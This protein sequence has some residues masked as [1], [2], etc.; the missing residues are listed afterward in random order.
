MEEAFSRSF[1]L[2]KMNMPRLLALLIS[3]FVAA[4]ACGELKIIES[5]ENPTHTTY[6]LTITPA[7]E[8]DPVF[9]HRFVLQDIDLLEG[10]AASYYYR[11]LHDI[12][13]QVAA[14]EKEFG[15]EQFFNWQYPSTC[16]LANLPCDKVQKGVGYFD[17][18]SLERGTRTRTCD[19]GLDI[20]SLTGTE[21]IS[22]ELDEFQSSRTLARVLALRA[23]VALAR[24]NFTNAVDDIWMIYRLSRDI[25]APPFIV[26]SLIGNANA[27][28]GNTGL[29]ELIAQPNAPNLY[30]AL[31]E[32]PDPLVD[33][34]NA[35]RFELQLGW[36]M[37]PFLRDAATAMRTADEWNLLWKSLS[38]SGL[39]EL[40]SNPPFKVRSGEWGSLLA[41]FEGYSHAKQRLIDWGHTKERVEAMST[42]QVLAI[43]TGQIYQRYAD[44]QELAMYV[45]WPEARELLDEVQSIERSEAIWNNPDREIFPLAAELLPALRL[46][47]M[48]EVR[49]QRELAVL[50]LI[51]A[52][53]MHAAENDGQLPAKLADVTC[54]PVPDNPATGEP[55]IYQVNGATAVLEL[56]A[57]DGLNNSARYEITLDK[58]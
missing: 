10:N 47:R 45:P 58:N 46:A 4:P 32:L 26:C 28:I 42:G 23:R 33:F 6:Q 12:N 19:W 35:V 14:V 41:G 3:A 20:S 36:K 15:E 17:T 48:V 22:F 37:A 1:P 54:V 38:K 5:P 31:A 53:R 57:S 27:S 44:R 7:P 8:P 51:E 25:T 40:M 29:R 50:R 21:F 18:A 13:R 39:D 9:T 52:L 11:A 34:R 2:Q 56:P 49:G 43:Y 30:W 16:N 24:G 55:F